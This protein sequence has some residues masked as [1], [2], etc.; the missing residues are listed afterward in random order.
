MAGSTAPSSSEW[1]SAFQSASRRIRPIIRYSGTTPS[2]EE[3]SGILNGPGHGTRHR[4]VQRHEPARRIRLAC[5]FSDC[6]RALRK[7]D[8]NRVHVHQCTDR[9][10]RRP[11][12]RRTA[13]T[14]R[15]TSRLRVVTRHH[16][17][18]KRADLP[19]KVREM[20]TD[21]SHR[22]PANSSP[23]EDLSPKRTESTPV[24][25][26]LRLLRRQQVEEL[27]GLKRAAIYAL[28]KSGRFPRAVMITERAVGWVEDEIHAWLQERTKFRKE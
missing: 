25:K 26:P 11:D 12:V 10:G 9:K 4:C 18:G 3:A 7:S 23:I 15:S 8:L 21:P 2:F 27:V 1:A 17:P 20:N 6:E 19:N 13:W 28:Q 16:V 14:S 5:R 22:Q 24:L